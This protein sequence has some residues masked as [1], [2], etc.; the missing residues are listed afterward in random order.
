MK[1]TR[2][3]EV[4]GR[5]FSKNNIRA[6]A[7]EYCDLHQ[8]GLRRKKPTTLKFKIFC[9]DGTIYETDNIDLFADNSYFDNKVINSLVM[10]V[11]NYSEIS[12]DLTIDKRPYATS[13]LTISSDERIWL[14]S[15]YNKL[16]DIINYAK[17]QDNWLLRHRTLLLNLI[18]LGF[19]F[20]FFMIIKFIIVGSPTSPNPEQKLSKFNLILQT[21]PTIRYLF[22]TILLWAM[23]LL[24]AFPIRDWLLQLWPEIEFDFGPEHSKIYKQRRNRIVFIF[25]IIIIP[26]IISYLVSLVT[27]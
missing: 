13:Q 20:A 2:S 6:L 10:S 18:A 1:E 8:S 15:T 24:S 19:G 21:Y 22:V 14:N 27:N 26:S 16:I 23:G 25:V 12:A 4:K 11:T 3:F 7:D 17:P 9:E 5:V